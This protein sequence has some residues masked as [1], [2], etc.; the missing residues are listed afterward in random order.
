MTPNSPSPHPDLETLADLAE[1]LVDPAEATALRQHLVNCPD[2]N[3]I[4]AA[5]TD[6]SLL[7]GSLD[8]PAI[9]TE[10]AD[11][12]DAALAAES[13]APALPAASHSHAGAPP[14][15]STGSKGPGRAGRQSTVRRR[16][17]TGLLVAAAVAVAGLTTTVS[18]LLQ[19]DPSASHSAAKAADGALPEY[20]DDQL[21]DQVHQ[22]LAA[23]PAHPHAQSRT[24]DANSAC[25]AAAAGHANGTPL[26]TGQGQYRGS[27]ATLLVYPGSNG[28]LDVYLV[29]GGCPGAT[30]LLHRTM[31]A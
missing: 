17:L 14:G 3:E 24:S 8:A 31:P 11:R 16:R 27:P 26:A 10:V 29:T 25:F 20:R 2:C 1:D 28:G 6:V 7:L 4:Y 9:P 22:L 19:P 12:I 15:R 21:T 30:V 18:L 5:L 23:Q 13:A